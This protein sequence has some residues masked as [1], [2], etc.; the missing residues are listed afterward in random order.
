MR[1]F[2]EREA[3]ELV[4]WKGRLSSP[5]WAPPNPWEASRA[6]RPQKV[7]FFLPDCLSQE[8]RR[9]RTS[10]A[11]GLRYTTDLP[12]S[13][14]FR[15]WLQ[16]HHQLSQGSKGRS[17]DFSAS[18][19]AWANSIY[20]LLTDYSWKSQTKKGYTK[21]ETCVYIHGHTCVYIYTYIYTHTHI[22]KSKD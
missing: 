13:Q 22:N 10:P 19:T 14:A 2:Q 7:E 3:F 17:W 15:C 8:S 4:G 1:V 5:V 11:L 21:A 9:Y 12:G 18:I 6:E 20:T 16:I